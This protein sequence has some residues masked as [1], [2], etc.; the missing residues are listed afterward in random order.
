[1][2]LGINRLEN[3]PPGGGDFFI[4]IQAYYWLER[5]PED[6]SQWQLRYIFFLMMTLSSMINSE[7]PPNVP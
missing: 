1:M 5:F 6:S 3:R 2:A 7:M 4:G